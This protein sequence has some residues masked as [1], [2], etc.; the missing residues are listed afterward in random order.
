[1]TAGRTTRHMYTMY[2]SMIE[3]G[4]GDDGCDE[5]LS[6]NHGY[7]VQAHHLISCSVMAALEGGKLARLAEKSGY[8]INRASNGIA[9]PAYF[10]HMRKDNKQRHRGGHW[11]TYYTNVKKQLDPIYEEHE[12]ADPCK[13]EKDR[14]SILNALKGAE[15]T[16]RGKLEKRT[17]WLYDWSQQLYDGDYRDEGAGNLNSARTREGSSTAG[18]QWLGDYP[19]PDVRRRHE[20]KGQGAKRKAHVRTKWYE[21]YGYPVPGSATS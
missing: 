13:N 1:M 12:D 10:G 18:L 2:K 14:K 19:K 21:G 11:E 5:T 17:W 4:F 16:I 8:D 6:Q 9:L 15:D 7:P 3:E 20:L